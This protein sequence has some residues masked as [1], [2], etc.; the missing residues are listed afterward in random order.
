MVEISMRDDV[1]C[2]IVA[3]GAPFVALG[4]CAVRSFNKFHPD[5]PMYYARNP[6][7]H[8]FLPTST[9]FGI[10]KEVVKEKKVS[11][12]IFLG[13]DTIVCSRLDEFLDDNESD[14][15]CTLDYPHHFESPRFT[16]KLDEPHLN[17]DVICF[18]NA[19]IL[20]KIIELTPLCY[21]YHEQG[22]LNEIVWS[23]DYNYTF[24]IV[25]HPYEESKVVYNARAK[26]NICAGPG[27]KPWAPYTRKFYVSDQKLFT[28]DDKQIKVWHYA[29]GFGSYGWDAT[30]TQEQMIDNRNNHI[31]GIVDSWVKEWFNE[32]T[33]EFFK[34]H[35]NCGDFF[36]R[37]S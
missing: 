13:A 35:C 7:F 9:R 12:L 24:K 22:A 10:A 18:N 30:L 27:E 1:A 3:F 19:E 4:D 36:E 17:V 32:E 26:G 28:G 34:E 37:G 5:I 25:D 15:I 33:K 14:V 23:D 16:S 20:D 2:V 31:N 21:P 6:D 8:Q 29:E 11:K